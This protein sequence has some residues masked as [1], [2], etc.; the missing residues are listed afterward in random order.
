VAYPAK[1]SM[2]TSMELIA[3]VEPKAGV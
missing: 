3:G 2:E 1:S